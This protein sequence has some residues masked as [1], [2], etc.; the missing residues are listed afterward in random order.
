MTEHYSG[1]DPETGCGLIILAM[2]G[3]FLIVAVI[4]AFQLG[5]LQ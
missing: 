1:N 2:I 5:R 4:I 3:A